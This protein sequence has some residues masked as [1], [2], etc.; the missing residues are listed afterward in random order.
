MDPQQMKD[1]SIESLLAETEAELART[2]V[3]IEA[4]KKLVDALQSS[5]HE[6]LHDEPDGSL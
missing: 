3:E 4:L 1:S 6:M 5:V 2:R